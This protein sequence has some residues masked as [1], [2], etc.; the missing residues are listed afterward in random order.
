MLPITHS[1]LKSFCWFV[2]EQTRRRRQVSISVGVTTAAEETQLKH[3]PVVWK[4]ERKQNQPFC[5]HLWNY[6]CSFAPKP[7]SQTGPSQSWE[8]NTAPQPAFIRAWQSKRL[9]RALSSPVLWQGSKRLHDTFTAACA[10]SCLAVYHLHSSSSAN[11]DQLLQFQILLSRNIDT[12][13]LWLEST[14]PNA[15][16]F[17]TAQMKSS[18]RRKGQFPEHTE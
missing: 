17:C 13:M 14:L 9:V 11:W 4:Q 16:Q 15:S 5:S 7:G 2:L 3:L 12:T 18:C 8:R 1:F 6:I 10:A